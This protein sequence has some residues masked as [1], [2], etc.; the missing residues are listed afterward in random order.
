MPGGW[1]PNQRDR[2]DPV[3]LSRVPR[4]DTRGAW[5]TLGHRAGP[6]PRPICDVPGHTTSRTRR[7]HGV[8]AEAPVG[9]GITR[10]GLD[11]PGAAPAPPASGI[12]APRPQTPPSASCAQ[13]RC[14]CHPAR[15]STGHLLLTHCG[16]DLPGPPRTHRG[17]SDSRPARAVGRRGSSSGRRLPRPV[18][19]VHVA[20][21]GP[22]PPVRP[23]PASASGA[24]RCW[25]SAVLPRASPYPL[26]TNRGGQPS[27]A[28]L[29]PL[30]YDRGL[31]VAFAAVWVAAAAV[32]LVSR[33]PFDRKVSRRICADS[34]PN[35]PETDIPG[36]RCAWRCRR[37]TSSDRAPGGGK[38]SVSRLPH[39]R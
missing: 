25:A 1:R 36:G 15:G 22:A 20:G 35:V 18:F 17:P 9:R 7:R 4:L 13:G 37:A 24:Q 30:G 5:W 16:I 33:A 19:P 32:A 21:P 10:S 3:Q 11:H 31:V 27:N 8:P 26:V 39:P 38:P 29:R 34:A 6:E 28:S 12:D 14:R 2:I 23:P